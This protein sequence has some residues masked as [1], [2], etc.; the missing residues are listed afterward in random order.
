MSLLYQLKHQFTSKLVWTQQA[1]FVCIQ[2]HN[3]PR[4]LKTGV[5]LFLCVYLDNLRE[6]VFSA[7][8]G[9]LESEVSCSHYLS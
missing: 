5:T 8:L 3:T 4:I 2:S 9:R 1:L 6:L 7:N